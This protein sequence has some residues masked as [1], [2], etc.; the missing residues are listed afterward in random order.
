MNAHQFTSRR[1][2][3]L[4]VLLLPTWAITL[5]LIQTEPQYARGWF[6]STVTLAALVVFY[7][8][9]R[10]IRYVIEHFDYLQQLAA[11]R[12]MLVFTI[13]VA[14]GQMLLGIAVQMG[15]TADS[16]DLVGIGAMF[17]TLALVWADSGKIIL[18]AYRRMIGSRGN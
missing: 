8:R 14:L 17:Q 9:S 11:W 2:V 15:L 13:F 10:Q 4:W 5:G 12:W 3:I 18:D 1:C 6:V 7:W 16:S